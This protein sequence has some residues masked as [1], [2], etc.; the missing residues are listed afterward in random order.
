MVVGFLRIHRS[1]DCSNR[2]AL[3]IPDND[4]S[5]RLHQLR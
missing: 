3:G 4:H 5:F 1:F 2:S